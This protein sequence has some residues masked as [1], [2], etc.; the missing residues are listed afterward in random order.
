MN[1]A[2][3]FVG[4]VSYKRKMFMK[5]TTGVN[6]VKLF[7]SVTYEFLYSARLFVKLGWKSLPGTNTIA[8][9]KH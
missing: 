6:L 3:Q 5:L 8:Y 4:V 7:T 9:C 1:G 2:T